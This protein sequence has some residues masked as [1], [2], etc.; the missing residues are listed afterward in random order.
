[1][2]SFILGSLIFLLTVSFII[3]VL[4]I[5][6]FNDFSDKVNDLVETIENGEKDPDNAKYYIEQALYDWRD[7]DD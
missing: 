2:S 6:V 5:G 7:S 4:L 3:N 1:M